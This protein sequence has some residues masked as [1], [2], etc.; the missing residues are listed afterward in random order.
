[1]KPLGSAVQDLKASM[2]VMKMV[3]SRA[4]FHRLI[5][6]LLAA[7]HNCITLS[8]SSLPTDLSSYF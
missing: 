4:A 6:H 2:A 8:Y 5:V 7:L 1:M 3:S